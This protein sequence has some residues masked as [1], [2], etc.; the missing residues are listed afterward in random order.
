MRK[1]GVDRERGLL[2]YTPSAGTTKYAT[3]VLAGDEPLGAGD[4]V[5][6]SF[7]FAML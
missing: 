6:E 7:L 3:H 5:G 2:L 4:G 1:T